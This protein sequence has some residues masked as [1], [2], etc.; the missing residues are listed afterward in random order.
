MLLLNIIAGNITLSSKFIN[1]ERKKKEKTAK[2][3]GYA[4]KEKMRK[5]FNSKE[6]STTDPLQSHPRGLLNYFSKV[7]K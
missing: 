6:P 1:K 2:A 3:K 5:P 7:L 4:N